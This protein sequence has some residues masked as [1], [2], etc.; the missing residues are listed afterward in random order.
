[1]QSVVDIGVVNVAFFGGDFVNPVQS[2]KS[3]FD[4]FFAAV[5]GDL[6]AARFDFN[7]QL[8][9]QPLQIVVMRAQHQH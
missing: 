2:G 8:F 3:V 5:H 9:F 4:V 6:I 1:M 7:A